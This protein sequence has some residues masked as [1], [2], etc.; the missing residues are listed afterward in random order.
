MDTYKERLLWA[1]KKAGQEPADL[2]RIVGVTRQAVDKLLNKPGAAFGST[3][4]TRAAIALGVDAVW[5]ATGEG[6][7]TGAETGSL[8]G[9]LSTLGS[10]LQRDMSADDRSDIAD[11]MHRMTMRGGTKPEQAKV[12]AMIQAV[13]SKQRSAA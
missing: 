5:L 11:A 2:P 8:E 7:P 6:S 3:N 10:H 13:Q 1:L 12:A 9:A 4:N